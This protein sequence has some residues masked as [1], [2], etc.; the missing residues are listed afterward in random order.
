MWK[1]G[2]INV[3]WSVPVVLAASLA[4]SLPSLPAQAAPTATTAGLA[5]HTAKAVAFDVSPPLREFASR[6]ALVPRAIRLHADRGPI[7]TESTF[8]GDRAV[9]S[10]ASPTAGIPAT[11]VNFR[12]AGQQR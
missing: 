2:R 7:P 12:G 10:T 9:Q 8:T 6:A 4:G 1:W 5:A 3:A 11:T